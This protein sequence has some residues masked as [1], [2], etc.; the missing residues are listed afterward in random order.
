MLKTLFVILGLAMIG[1]CA[2]KSKEIKAK[3][4][5]KTSDYCVVLDD[6]AK[7]TRCETVEV[8]CYNT[9]CFSKP[10]KVEAPKTPEVKK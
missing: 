2:G 5:F 6:V 1:G 8:I 4:P 7:F 10:A 9:A 3:A